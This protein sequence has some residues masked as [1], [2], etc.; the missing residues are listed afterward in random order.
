MIDPVREWETWQAWLG[1]EPTGTTIYAQVAEM[2]LSRQVWDGFAIV[3]DQAPEGAREDG[4]YLWWVRFKYARSKGSRS[5]G[6]W[7][8]APTWSR[9]NV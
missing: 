1:Q 6:R 7:N 9:S 2:V 8:R 4:T 3:H 5:E